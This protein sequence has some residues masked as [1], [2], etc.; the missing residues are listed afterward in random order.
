LNTEEIKAMLAAGRWAEVAE[1]AC[2]D[3]RVVRRLLS[4]L[5]AAEDYTHWLA[6]EAIGHVGGA[7]AASDPEQTRELVRR[8][9]WNLNDES[10]GTPWGA[11]GGVGAIAAAR[12]DLFSG[13]LSLLFP[14]AGDAAAGPEF[15]W[16]VARVGRGRPDTVARYIPFL[17]SQLGHAQALSRAYAAWAL[18][19]LAVPQTAV[20]LTGLGQDTATVAIYEGDGCYRVRTV[21]QIALASGERIAAG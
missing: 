21:G 12:P 19:V 17:L 1:L 2:L 20:P 6:I 9:L 10:G 11:V 15:I 16:S 5:Y 8:L 14:F 7:L 18:G 4:L 13:Y 3:R